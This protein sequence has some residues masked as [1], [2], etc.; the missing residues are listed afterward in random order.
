MND[1]I[2]IQV[3]HLYQPE[4]AALVA[5]LR[6]LAPEEWNQH[7]ACAAWTV[8]DVALHILGGD[9]AIVARKRDRFAVPLPEA[10]SFVQSLNLHNAQWI[11]SGRR[12]SPE[13]AIDLLEHVGSQAFAALGALDL[14]AMGPS[15]YWAGPG[16]APVWLDVAREYTERWHHQ[17]HIRDAVDRPG[18]MDATFAGPVFETFVQALP[19]S[20]REVEAEPGAS[21]ELRVSGDAGGRWRLTRLVEGWSLAEPDA[22]QPTSLVEMPPE[23]AWKMYTGG[24]PLAACERAAAISGDPKLAQALFTTRAIIV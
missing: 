4:R 18:L 13:L 17:Q 16:P 2:P 6:D 1:A 19:W 5:L 14:H 22:S 11:A 12:M 7:T 23:V 9:I 20:F 15:V 24:L 21:L 3:M 10:E 8:K